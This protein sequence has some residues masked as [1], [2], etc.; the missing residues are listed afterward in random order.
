MKFFKNI[1]IICDEKKY[2]SVITNSTYN[3]FE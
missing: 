2:E 3:N 1:E